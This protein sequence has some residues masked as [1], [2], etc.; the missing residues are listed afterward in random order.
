[1]NPI[2]NL[3]VTDNRLIKS[4]ASVSVTDPVRLSPTT[5][6][7]THLSGGSS[8][9]LLGAIRDISLRHVS[10][11]PV[12]HLYA[13]SHHRLCHSTTS[14][15]TTACVIALRHVSPPPVS[16]H[17]A[18]SHHLLCHI[19]T[20]CLITACVISLRHVSSPPV[21]HL[22]AMSHHRLCHITTPCLITAFVISLRHVSQPP[23]SCKFISQS[24]KI[25]RLFPNCT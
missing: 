20:P 2:V 3:L 23:M 1:M 19:T 25:D 10:Q 5:A 8:I 24:C 17:Y 22:Y 6:E 13:M 12:S 4:F 7:V 18:M 21:S 15:L 14:C 9:I 16:N 11:P